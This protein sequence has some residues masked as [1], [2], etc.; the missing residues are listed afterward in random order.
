M[1]GGQASSPPGRVE[2]YDRESDRFLKIYDAIRFFCYS[3]QEYG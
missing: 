3:G 1:E 2:K